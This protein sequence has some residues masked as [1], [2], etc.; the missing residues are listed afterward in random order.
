MPFLPERQD[1]VLNLGRAPHA[2]RSDLE[3]HWFGRAEIV[4][5]SRGDPTVEQRLRDIIMGF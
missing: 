2:H 4:I 5:R 3:T 1:I